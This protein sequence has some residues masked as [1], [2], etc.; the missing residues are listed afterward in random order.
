VQEIQAWELAQDEQE[1]LKRTA[2]AMAAAARVVDDVL[3]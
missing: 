3:G 1:G 2:A